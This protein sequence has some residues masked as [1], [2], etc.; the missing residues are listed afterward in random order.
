[1]VVVG[2][3]AALVIVGIAVTIVVAWGSSI[4][5]RSA[6]RGPRWA[7]GHLATVR[8]Y[9]L[10]GVAAGLVLAFVVR[11]LWV[12]LAVLY[13]ALTVLL[14]AATLRRALVK[15][16]DAGGLDDLP[17]ERRRHIVRRARSLIL[18]AGVVLA[19]IGIGGSVAGEGAVAWIPAVLGVT[20][21]VTALSLS[22]ENRPEA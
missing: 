1:M 22:A 2:P 19:A 20:L 17:I 5:I 8:P 4:S 13:V 15:L 14:L 11:P 7:L 3:D 6:A 10:G 21:V 12:G 9:V 18:I 16:E